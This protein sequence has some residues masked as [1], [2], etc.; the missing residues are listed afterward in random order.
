MDRIHRKLVLASVALLAIAAVAWRWAPA[1]GQPEERLVVYSGRNEAL[2][3]PPIERFEEETGIDVQVRYGETSEMAAAILEEGPNSPA[4]LFFA[5]DAGALGA[6]AAEGRLARLPDRL[7]E[8]V[9]P[10]FRSPRGEWVGVTGRARVVACSTERVTP[11]Q[12]PGSIL[13]F[14][15]P[16]WKGRIGWPPT[17]GSFQAFVTALRVTLGE[18][19]A[20]AWLEGIQANQPRVYRNNTAAIQA[21][22]AGEVDVAFV[23]HYYLYRFLAE[24]GPS[25]PVR[26]Y[27]PR[28]GGAGAMINVAGVGVLKDARHPKAAE[29][30]VDF[31]LSEEAQRYFAGETYEYPLVTGV[32]A[33]PR[34]VPL[35]EI[36]TPEIDLGDLAG[37][38][39][40]LDLL[41]ETGAL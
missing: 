1:S 6:V 7:L 10:R 18:D 9:E 14:T 27:H 28:D 5:Q 25:F 22:A 2:V 3:G 12:M 26:N 8:R 24:E 15:D 19:G 21:V 38:E 37:L 39:R 35:P 23:N 11:D 36:R 33:D 31:L 20:R 30:F 34:L 16:K 17:N 29:A 41:W 40:T 32:P 4:D 13:G